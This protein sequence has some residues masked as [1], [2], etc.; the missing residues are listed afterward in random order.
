MSSVF[1]C[2]CNISVLSVYRSYRNSKL[3]I[4]SLQYLCVI[5]PSYGFFET[6]YLLFSNL[7]LFCSSSVDSPKRALI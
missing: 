3:W 1:T 6:F 4:T 5:Q 2:L 7:L